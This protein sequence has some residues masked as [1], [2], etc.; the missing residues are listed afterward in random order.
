MPQEDLK[1]LRQLGSN[2][3]GHPDALKQPFVE[4]STGSLGQGF[5]VAAGIALSLKMDGLPNKVY[6]LLGDGETQ[7]GT[8]YQ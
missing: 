8:H 2:L 3:Q 6:T 5:G 7:E 1:T 4:V